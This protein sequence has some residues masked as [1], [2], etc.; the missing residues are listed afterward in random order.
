MDTLDIVFVVSLGIVLGAGIEMGR[1]AMND[2]IKIIR[3]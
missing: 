2:L 3:K 1:I